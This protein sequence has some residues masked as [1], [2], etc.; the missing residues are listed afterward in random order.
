SRR[1]EIKKRIDLRELW[2]VVGLETGEIGIE[3]LTELVFGNQSDAN[4]AASLLRAIFEDR[5]Y[6]RIRPD[7]IEV[8]SPEQVQQALIQREKERERST[9]I[10]RCAEFLTR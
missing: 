8:P 4:C 2:G 1:E 9:F 7:R 6:F 10:A 5:L 3:D